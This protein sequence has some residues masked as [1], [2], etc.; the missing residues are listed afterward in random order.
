MKFIKATKKDLNFLFKLR[1][2]NE[3]AKYSKRGY[4]KLVEVEKDYLQNS[5]KKVY[6]AKMK[7]ESVGYLIFE[8]LSK[9]EF[10][11]SVAISTNY[12]GKGS[13][14]LIVEKGT[15][16]GINIL[17]AQQ[18]VAQIFPENIP[19]LKIFQTNSY[20][21]IDKSFEPWKLV[22]NVSKEGKR[23]SEIA[24]IF[25]FDGVIADSVSSLSNVYFDFLK[26]F[27]VNGN[28]E[29]FNLL[30]GPKLSEIVHFLKE[31]YKIDKDEKVLLDLYLGKIS[32]AYKNIK[33]NN[34]IKEILELLRG[35]KIKTVLASSSKKEE[36][37]AV[38]DRYNLN[39]LF[40][41]I[42]TGDDV[43]E[44]KPSPEIYNAVKN[45]YQGNDYYV[46]E[47]SENGLKAAIAAEMKTILYTSKQNNFNITPTYTINSLSQIKD[48][49]TEIELNCFTV[50]KAENISL[51]VIDYEPD[52]SPLQKDIIEKLWND[53][54]KKRKLF[55][56]KIVSY[57]SHEKKGNTLKIECFVTQYK[58]F[59]A[60][61]RD[62]QLNLKITPI[63]VSGI[64]ID[65][66]NN[67][68]LAIRQ[69]VTE[70]NGYYELIPA[71]S[72][73]PSKRDGNNILF[74]DQLVAEFEEETQISKDNIKT[75]KPFCLIFDKAH[76]VYDICSKIFINGLIKNKLNTEQNEEYKKIEI[77]DLNILLSSI[78]QNK[79]VPTSIIILNNID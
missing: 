53:E 44:A 78:E 50:A 72:I 19:S 71:G 12:R 39:D 58:Y 79:F 2:E 22:Y 7:G 16:F 25:D 59:F 56:G 9:D 69:N 6:V 33:L 23:E 11:I 65:E 35:K 26:K 41:F 5:K 37:V 68:L 1:N 30:N 62:P 77:M 15:E 28:E 27:G 34:G 21:I 10:E 45:K 36:I 64:I 63:G 31:K 60:Q 20:S 17:G 49:L 54:L 8:S 13:G 47:D 4:L 42:I 40:D 18:I 73:D 76:G 57:K 61:L 51:K 52:F 46:I 3:S 55:N 66:K 75:T 74:K 32:S 29:E 67:T 14:R 43:Q 38:L 70:Y 24:F 48:I